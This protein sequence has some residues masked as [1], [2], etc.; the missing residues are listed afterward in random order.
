M[1][2]NE[3]KGATI[4]E[5]NAQGVKQVFD[6]NYSPLTIEAKELFHE[7]QKFVLSVFKRA[8]QTQNGKFIV[9]KHRDKGNAQ[10][11]WKD[12]WDVYE[13]NKDGLDET[14]PPNSMESIEDPT[15]STEV[16]A[17]SDKSETFYNVDN[18]R[19]VTLD[20]IVLHAKTE[21]VYREVEE[22]ETATAGTTGENEGCPIS[23]DLEP[24]PRNGA[25]GILSIGL[26]PSNLGLAMD[27]TGTQP[28]DLELDLEDLD[29]GI[30]VDP[31]GTISSDLEPDPRDL[32]YYQGG[33]KDSIVN[34]D[35]K[36]IN[37]T[38]TETLSP[39]SVCQVLNQ[40]DKSH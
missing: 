37:Q 33:S 29:Q 9:R 19:Q 6:H 24:D 18:K 14:C 2:W 30:S 21:R 17:T 8:L 38:N 5:A 23:S 40:E 10:E 31:S 39:K 20:E 1:D 34:L 32:E 7:E 12:V 27:T 28:S 26:K 11:V 13:G 22:N 25:T 16:L 4:T 15:A 36:C 3:F 35:K